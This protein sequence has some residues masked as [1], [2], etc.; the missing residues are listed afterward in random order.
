MKKHLPY[1]VSRFAL[2][3]P[4]P[5]Q[6]QQQQNRTTQAHWAGG[7]FY[8]QS[9]SHSLVHWCEEELNIIKV[10][11]Q[12]EEWNNPA[13]QTQ[14]QQPLV[15]AHAQTRISELGRTKP[16]VPF[17]RSLKRFYLLVVTL[18]VFSVA[19]QAQISLSATS[20]TTSGSYTTLKAAF[21]AVNLGTHKG[22]VTITVTANT[23]E[24][25]SAVLN[26]SGT[27]GTSY[28]GLSIYP[29]ASGLSIT[30]QKCDNRREYIWF[31]WHP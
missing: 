15:T 1:P 11:P 2:S 24:T 8:S 16:A 22:V 29:T 13:L 23:T 18:L 10:T 3:T 7:S 17:S 19:S 20:G 12:L 21:D 27:G 5:E 31:G 14:N 28:T 26:A 25:A 4:L 9:P 6:V 30:G